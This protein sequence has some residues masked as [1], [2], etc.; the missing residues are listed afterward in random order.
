M[1]HDLIGSKSN[2][3]KNFVEH[4]R[5]KQ[6]AESIGDLHPI[7]VDEEYG[8]KS[9]YGRNIAPPTY[10]RVF[11]FG[12]LEQVKLPSK[13]LIHGEQ[14]YIFKRPLFVGEEVYCYT[15]L[16]NYYEKTG[17]NGLMGFVVIKRYG[18]DPEGNLIF[19]EEMTAIITETVRK[20]M[21][22]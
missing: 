9:K 8:R 14:R 5:V 10:P 13:G 4:G 11:D 15:E 21:K 22:V 12:V 20:A 19:T 6:F 18:E 16:Q 3:V 2:K 1:F 7:Y 17:G